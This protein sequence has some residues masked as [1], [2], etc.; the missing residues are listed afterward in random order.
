MSSLRYGA[1]ALTLILFIVGII[2]I[3]TAPPV[4]VLPE[5]DDDASVSSLYQSLA[6]SSPSPHAKVGVR[7][8]VQREQVPLS[9]L[10]S[11]VESVDD[12]IDFQTPP[13]RPFTRMNDLF[14]SASRSQSSPSAPVNAPVSVPSH[15]K[16][17]SALQ[18]ANLMSSSKS[19]VTPTVS[20]RKVSKSLEAPTLSSTAGS[21]SAS[22]A[23]IPPFPDF[24]SQSKSQVSFA[25]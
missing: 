19:V 20:A 6:S 5:S 1:Y 22:L 8:E 18:P 12:T 3:M 10:S 15:S 9:A 4:K 24:P 11:I 7:V 21:R 14:E 17:V 16:S 13:D 25:A 2:L 23:N